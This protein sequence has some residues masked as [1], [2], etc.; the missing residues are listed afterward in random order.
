MGRRRPAPIA[1]VRAMTASL[2]QP[3]LRARRLGL[4]SQHQP[5]VIMRTDCHVCQA[6]GLS[7]RSQVLLSAGDR[8]VR[9]LLYQVEGDGLLAPG[10]AALSEP[11]WEMLGVVQGDAIAVTHASAVESLANVRRRIYGHRLDA[12]AL[13]AIVGDVAQGHSRSEER[14]VGQECVSR[15]RS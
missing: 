11:A 15:C 12:G 7:G 13:T 5:I 2:V 9:A 3:T 4:H 6:E 8:E 1:G 10:E 14:R